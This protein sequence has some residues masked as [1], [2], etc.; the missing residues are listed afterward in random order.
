MCKCIGSLALIII[1]IIFLLVASALIIV[2]ALLQWGG[3]ALQDQIIPGISKL[4]TDNVKTISFQ[5]L[6]S[7]MKQYSAVLGNAGLIIFIIGIILFVIC[8]C[9]SF[10]VCCKSRLL[11][12]I[13]LISTLAIWILIIIFIIVFFVK[14]SDLINTGQVQYRNL[15][16]TEYQFNNGSSVKNPS[17]L[18][19]SGIV[20][21]VQ[22]RLMCCGA[23]NSTDFVSTTNGY[24]KEYGIIPFSCCKMTGNTFTPQDPNCVKSPSLAN[25]NMNTGCYTIL[26]NMI[27]K[28][29][30]YAAWG[31]V[32]LAIIL[33]ILIIIA[34][35]L[36][37][38]YES[39]KD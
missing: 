20:D 22:A 31:L 17:G 11:L 12:I 21:L 18:G 4:T 33:F 19:V 9:G 10:G 8:L 15:L 2:G 23:T 36:Q 39:G 34:G 3:S 1:N 24:N 28:Y 14:R 37:K 38:S 16:Q 6:T 30:E 13:Y 5:E 29:F 35:V 32:G 7:I 27:G 25:S 26:S